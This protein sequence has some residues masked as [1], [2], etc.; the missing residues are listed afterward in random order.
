MYYD[1]FVKLRGDDLL[2]G[3]NFLRTHGFV[4]ACFFE[5]FP[6]NVEKF[7]V[8]KG[9][10]LEANSVR[11][12]KSLLKSKNGNFTV[13]TTNNY[14]LLKI[15]CQKGLVDAI[16]TD[17]INEVIAKFAAQTKVSLLID[18]RRLLTAKDR[19]VRFYQMERS[20][21]IAQKKKMPI[22]IGSGATNYFELR[23]LSNLLSFSRLLGIKR[24]KEPFYLPQLEIIKREKARVEGK[25][26]M[27]GVVIE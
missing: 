4:G 13:L 24:Y 23:A 11:E 2:R 10:E 9:V 15:A 3:I 21:S 6:E 17:E 20:C 18:F 14:N 12:L 8:L 1:F 26:V 7:Q 5:E 25:Y 19:S 16:H 27:P 22:I